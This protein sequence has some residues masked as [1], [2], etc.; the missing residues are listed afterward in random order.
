[1][2]P[3]GLPGHNMPIDMNIE[4]LIGYLKALFAAKGLYSNWE[5]LGSISALIN[6]LQLIKKKVTMSLGCGYQGSTHKTPN[7]SILVFRIADRA[8]ELKLQEYVESHE[9]QSKPVLD[10]HC[11]GY[12]K[13][14]SASLA[15]FNKKI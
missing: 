7:T 3:S 8:R 12:Q 11:V 5:R 1:V 9:V 6:Y 15:I 4:H 14:G 13:F 2:N 10:L